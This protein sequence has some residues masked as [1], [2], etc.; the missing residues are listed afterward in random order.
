MRALQLIEVSD[1]LLNGHNSK[2]PLRGRA[3]LCFLL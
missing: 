1:E 3:P 2:D